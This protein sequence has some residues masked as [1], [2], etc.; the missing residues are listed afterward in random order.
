MAIDTKQPKGAQAPDPEQ[1]ITS[2]LRKA[3]SD[4]GMLFKSKPIRFIVHKGKE[5]HHA[6]VDG[7]YNI[8]SAMRDKIEQS[9]PSELVLTHEEQSE[10]LK[11]NGNVITVVVSI[12]TVGSEFLV[13][14]DGD[15]AGVLEPVVTEALNNQNIPVAKTYT[16]ALWTPIGEGINVYNE[17]FASI[18]DTI[19]FMGEQGILDDDCGIVPVKRAD[20]IEWR[21]LQNFKENE[22]ILNGTHPD[23]D[24]DDPPTYNERINMIDADDLIAIIVRNGNTLDIISKNEKGRLFAKFFEYSHMQGIE[25]Y[26]PGQIVEQGR[27]VDFDSHLRN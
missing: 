25:D 15:N 19:K 18:Y 10:F 13:S 20:S 26:F 27:I 16:T 23:I 12:A 14:I 3:D 22:T 7:P 8:P 1:I 24:W 6:I 11:A 5:I 21:I 17:V 4:S 9:K 2:I